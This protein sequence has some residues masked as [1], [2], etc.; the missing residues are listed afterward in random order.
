MLV[1]DEG[2]FVVCEDASLSRSVENDAV[3]VLHHEQNTRESRILF[4]PLITE[5]ECCEC[6]T[7]FREGVEFRSERDA[8][9]FLRQIVCELFPIARGV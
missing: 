6:L 9:Y 5:V 1:D 4:A 7:C 8:R 2:C 3:V